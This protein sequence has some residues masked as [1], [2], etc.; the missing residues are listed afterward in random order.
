[1]RSIPTEIPLPEA[2]TFS[3]RMGGNG[4]DGSGGGSLYWSGADAG[5][6][7]DV[8]EEFGLNRLPLGSIWESASTTRGDTMISDTGRGLLVR[9][10][11]RSCDEEASTAVPKRRNRSALSR[12]PASL[13]MVQNRHAL[14]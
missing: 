10:M 7:S 8:D 1:M 14:T 2:T 12:V 3:L 11:V 4:A 6:F 9:G 13:A 5:I